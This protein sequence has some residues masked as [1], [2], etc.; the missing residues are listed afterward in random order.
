[1]TFDLKLFF[2]V[3]NQDLTS[4]GGSQSTA[5]RTGHS[6]EELDR[7]VG[8]VGGGGGKGGL[9]KRTSL[10][11]KESK[12]FTAP[13]LFTFLSRTLATLLSEQRPPYRGPYHVLA[14]CKPLGSR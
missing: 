9:P 8:V 2:S 13:G 4:Q 7:V 10:G 3:G 6:S 5:E 14:F 11:R 1:M 12:C